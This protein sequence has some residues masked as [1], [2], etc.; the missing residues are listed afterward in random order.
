LLRKGKSK[1]IE[2]KLLEIEENAGTLISWSESR[3]SKSRRSSYFRIATTLGQNPIIIGA[4]L[5]MSSPTSVDG[6]TKTPF[7]TV[8][9]GRDVDLYLLSNKNGMEASVTTYGGIITSLTAPDRRGDFADVVLGFSHLEGYLAGHPY[10]GAIVGRYANR[11][12]NGTFT[13]DDRAYVLALNNNGNHLHGGMAGFDKKLWLA[14]PQSGLEGPQLRLSYTS[15]DGEEGYPGRL[16][17]AVTYTLTHDHELRIEYRATTDKATHV[18]LSNHSYCNLSGPGGG[19]ILGHEV[20]IDSDRFTPVDDRLIPTG[21]IRTVDGTPL[22]FREAVAIG[23]RI[24]D[25]DEQLRFS[26]GYDHNFVLNSAD[27]ELS[28][29]ARVFEPTTGR[30]MDVLTSEP[31]VQFYTANFLDGTLTGKEGHVYGRRCALCLETQHFPDSPNRPEFPT[32][33]LRPGEVYETTTVYQFS[34]K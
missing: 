16:D 3:E 18:N 34:A 27:G 30:M 4:D 28:F 31:G 23:K 14:R 7:G 26:N 11:I 21:E 13:L 24:E 9:G 19:D 17:I 1:E 25:D 32:T 20:L 22:D 15:A 5:T 33:V 29:A 6:I 8:P 10:F 2:E 12:G